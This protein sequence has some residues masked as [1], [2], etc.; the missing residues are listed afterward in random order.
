MGRLEIG[1]RLCL[2]GSPTELETREKSIRALARRIWNLES[3]PHVIISRLQTQ[4]L[5]WLY[6]TTA[7]A[8]HYSL[9]SETRR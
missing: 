2:L 6:N 9:S 3:E 8:L 5:R 1:T 7:E 4:Y